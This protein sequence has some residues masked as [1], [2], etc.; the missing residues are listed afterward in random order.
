M[1]KLLSEYLAEKGHSQEQFDRMTA[2]KK[3]EI[4]N[5][6]NKSN[7][8]ASNKLAEKSEKTDAEIA[9][10]AEVNAE[11]TKQ[12]GTLML[13]VEKMGIELA[14][15]QRDTSGEVSVS[16]K[17]EL[18]EHNEAIKAL[19]NRESSVEVA[20][21]AMTNTGAIAPNSNSQLDSNIGQLD[22]RTLNLYNMFS[23]VKMTGNSHNNTYRYFDWDEATTVR[24]AAVVAEGAAFPES[25]AKWTE[26]SISIKKIGDSLPVTEEFFEDE[27]MFA[28][29]LEKFLRMN[30]DILIDSKLLTGAGGAD[31]SGLDF[32]MTAYTAVAAG[33][34]DASIYDLIVKVDEN[35]KATTGNKYS[36]NF[37]LMNIVDINRMKLKKDGNNNYILPPFVDRNGAVVAGI[38]VVE[39]NGV[40]ANEMYVGDTRYASIIEIGGLTLAKGEVNNQ[41]LED[42]MTLKIRKRLN[43]LIKDSDKSGFR[44]V[45]DI[46]AALVI[47]AS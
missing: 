33:I 10:Q 40:T 45:T 2:E 38:N 27:G 36:T 13:T 46:D 25:T 43:L 28:S 4:F 17:S 29:E 37:A 6:L 24:A 32:Y 16:L 23:K 11:A 18:K 20:L 21:K 3:A 34:T 41:F 19:A 26:K 31:L 9:K 35:I 42:T 22:V 1:F 12:L 8:E 47:L 30:V 5:E 44:R 15:A 14:K 7:I 39:N